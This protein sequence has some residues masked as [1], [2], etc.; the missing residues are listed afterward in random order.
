MESYVSDCGVFLGRLL[1][2]EPR[3]CVGSF[4]LS[5]VVPS[6]PGDWRARG[7][8]P[9]WTVPCGSLAKGVELGWGRK[10]AGRGRG[11]GGGRPSPV[12]VP[13]APALSSFQ[14]PFV[15]PAEAR[16]TGACMEG[17]VGAWTCLH[18]GKG[19]Q[20]PRVHAGLRTRLLVGALPQ[21]HLPVAFS[22][23][24]RCRQSSP[25]L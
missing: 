14:G 2:I 23:P 24:H 22:G 12:L 15:S 21:P 16:G 8:M 18:V 4:L 10:A 6:S 11:V 7:E 9:C 25:G 13:L 3:Q 19:Q 1:C 17:T 20:V 5:L